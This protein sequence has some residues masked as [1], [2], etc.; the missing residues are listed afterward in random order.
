MK[1]LMSMLTLLATIG[2]MTVACDTDG[3]YEEAGE[4]VGLEE[5]GE[6]MDEAVEETEDELEE[7]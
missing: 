6:A 5:Q 7:G 1:K 4:E 3:P 2:V